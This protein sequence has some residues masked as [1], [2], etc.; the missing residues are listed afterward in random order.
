MEVNGGSVAVQAPTCAMTFSSES[1][2]IDDDSSQ[3]K[4][5]IKREDKPKIDIEDVDDDDGKVIQ[6]LLSEKH[7]SSVTFMLS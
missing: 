5:L 3:D 1:D 2:P 4:G 7:V 6:K